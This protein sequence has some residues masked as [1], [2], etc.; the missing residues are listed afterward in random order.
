[1]FTSLSAWTLPATTV[2]TVINPTLVMVSVAIAG[3]G[4]LLR[5]ARIALGLHRLRVIRESSVPAGSLAPIACA[6]QDAL[7][8]DADIRF[9]TAI[10]SPATFGARRAT[11]LLPPSIAQLPSGVQEAILCHELMHVRRRDW[12]ATMVEELWCAL[13]WFHPAARALTSQLAFVR[14]TVV[15]EATIAR[16]GNRRAYA[17]A[18]LA[19]TSAEPPIVGAAALIGR[20]RFEHR[21]A[22]ISQEAQMDLK[23]LS[24]RMCVAAFAVVAATILTTAV[25]PLNV[26]AAAQTQQ[27]Y[28]PGSG[29]ALPRVIREVKPVYTPE[30]MR[31]RI[32]GT[33][34][35][36]AV[37]LA[38]G[39]VGEV[40]VRK[41]LDEEHGLDVAAIDAL[42]QWTF[43]PGTKNGE[44]VAVEVTVEMTFTLKK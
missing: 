6:L 5:L 11:V 32:Q 8:T 16:T 4:V 37:V 44:P 25:V 3:A 41:S 9:T 1:V 18:L 10:T 22:L 40:T 15:D 36:R 12:L 24:L 14:E 7:S 35:L 33:V 39:E 19:F 17:A 27:V 2:A 21:I 23:A 13:L 29:V 42:K 31:A 34:W 30:A 20:R 43:K 38:S 28:Q 26:T